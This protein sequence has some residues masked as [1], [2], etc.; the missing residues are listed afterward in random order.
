[1]IHLDT[2]FVVRSLIPGTTQDTQLRTWL[3]A[4]EVIRV[5]AIVWAEFL[6]GPLAPGVRSAAEAFITHV[7]PLNFDDAA[8]AAELFNLGGR[9]RGSLADCMIAAICLRRGA[10]LATANIADFQSF[11]NEGLRII[12]I[13]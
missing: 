10:A 2:N 13:S 11:A 1:M 5:D 4:G 8:R 9:R 12:H 7:E 6:C 3:A